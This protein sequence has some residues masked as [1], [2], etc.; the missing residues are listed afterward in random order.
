VRK[1]YQGMKDRCKEKFE[2]LGKRE[3]LEV[4]LPMAEVWAGGSTLLL[5]ELLHSIF[6]ALR[7]PNTPRFPQGSCND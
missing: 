3:L 7:D 1:T 2:V 5:R 4:P 6:A